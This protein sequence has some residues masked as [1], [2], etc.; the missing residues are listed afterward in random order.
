MRKMNKLIYVKKIFFFKVVLFDDTAW[1]P[2]NGTPCSYL[3]EIESPAVDN[4]QT[5]NNDVKTLI[6][7]YKLVVLAIRLQL[8]KIVI[9]CHMRWSE[10][11]AESLI[12]V[13]NAIQNIGNKLRLA[14]N[15][16]TKNSDDF[17][18]I[19]RIPL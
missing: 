1:N 12:L 15:Y 8:Y 5:K 10:H 6:T 14:I 16:H 3:D 17:I 18:E 19:Y 13:V 4:S 2:R 11:P 9:N 7:S